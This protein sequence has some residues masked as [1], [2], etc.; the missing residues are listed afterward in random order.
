MSTDFKMLRPEPTAQPGETKLA[1][2]EEENGSAGPMRT[3]G[4][5]DPA[6]SQQRK[7]ELVQVA[8]RL[9]CTVTSST[10]LAFMVTAKQASVVS[11]Y[12]FNIPIHSKW[13]F[14]DSFE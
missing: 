7:V 10:A 1:A 5:R 13:S 14:S 6:V 3:I 9:L 11:I 4:S 12:G 2:L 8:M